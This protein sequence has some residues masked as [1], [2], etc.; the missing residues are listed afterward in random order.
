M[1]CG[2]D[3]TPHQSDSSRFAVALHPAVM[4]R[5]CV[6]GAACIPV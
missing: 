5:R 6:A 1:I 3:V 4:E 2:Y